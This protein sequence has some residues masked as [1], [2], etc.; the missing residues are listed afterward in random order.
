[1]FRLV[2]ELAQVLYRDRWA[3]RMKFVARSAWFGRSNR[4]W[5]RTLVSQRW[6]HQ[7][8]LAQPALAER[9]HRPYQ[10]S[11]FDRWDRLAVLRQHYRAC[12]ELGWQ[13]LCRRIADEGVCLG[14][15]D[16]RD[17]KPLTLELGYAEQFA[18]EGEWA[19]SL[20]LGDERLYTMV[21]SLRVDAGGRR[22][23]IGCVQGPSSND[24]L[25]LVRDLTRSLH[26]ERPRSL[27]L[28]AARALA[29]EAG[30]V[31]LELVA[32]RS[33]IYRNPRRRRS[34]RFRYDEF[35]TEL[36]GAPTTSGTWLIPVSV[37]RR[38]IA[39]VASKR[40]AATLRKRALI[41]TLRSQVVGVVRAQGSA[42]A[43][44]GYAS[45]SPPPA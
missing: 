27:L 39:A 26:G 8:L 5:L 23:F 6:T 25:A 20:R 4:D 35:A 43:V 37:P 19:L 17:G 15:I 41:D 33:H 18:K 32:D 40:R 45:E 36:D 29:A 2:H 34:I 16:G 22:L 14:R 42:A 9:L 10:Q 30:C 38:P 3:H 24:G 1:M 11:G 28:E 13:S 12:G 31:A 44:R 21:L 7:L